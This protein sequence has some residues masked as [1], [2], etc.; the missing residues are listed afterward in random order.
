MPGRLGELQMRQYLGKVTPS[1][2]HPLALTD[3]PDL[4]LG[5]VPLPLH[6]GHPP[7]LGDSDPQHA[8]LSPFVG[9]CLWELGGGWMSSG[10]SNER[11][12]TQHHSQ[13]RI[14]TH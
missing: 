2:E 1:R 10:L 7:I 9:L 6:R 4:L 3:L 8:D 13:G 12:T 11:G 14:V 5:R